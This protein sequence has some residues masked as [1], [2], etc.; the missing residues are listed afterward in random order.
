LKSHPPICRRAKKQSIL[1]KNKPKSGSANRKQIKA[2]VSSAWNFRLLLGS[3]HL[4]VEFFELRVLP[5]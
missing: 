1:S 3:C 2:R 5:D 4:L